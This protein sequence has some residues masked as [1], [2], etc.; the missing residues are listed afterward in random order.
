LGG[1]LDGAYRGVRRVVCSIRA[2]R[3]LSVALRGRRVTTFVALVVAI[4]VAI[5]AR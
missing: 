3:L 5:V 1:E 4:L 2:R